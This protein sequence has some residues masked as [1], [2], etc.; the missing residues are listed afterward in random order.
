MALFQLQQSSKMKRCWSLLNLRIP[1]LIF[2]SFLVILINLEE[3]NIKVDT[4]I[5]VENTYSIDS[6][7]KLSKKFMLEL[8]MP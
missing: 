4:N 6:P 3:N 7:D 8:K 1:G 5:C 2:F